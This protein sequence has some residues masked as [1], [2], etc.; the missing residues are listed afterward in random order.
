MDIY[1]YKIMSYSDVKTNLKKKKNKTPPAPPRGGPGG[2]LAHRAASV[3]PFSS[4]SFKKIKK[5]P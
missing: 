4:V 1:K 2:F 5:I 3:F